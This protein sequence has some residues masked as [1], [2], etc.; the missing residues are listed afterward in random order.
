MEKL[1]CILFWVFVV[2]GF[3]FFLFFVQQSDGD[4]WWCLMSVRMLNYDK[5]AEVF[6]FLQNRLCGWKT[7]HRVIVN[8]MYVLGTLLTKSCAYKYTL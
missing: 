6:F 5:D 2:L 7:S 1:L 8:N 3:F 4:W